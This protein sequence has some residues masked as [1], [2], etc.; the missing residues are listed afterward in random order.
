MVTSFKLKVVKDLL[1]YYHVLM[2]LK[3]LSIFFLIEINKKN[4][5]ILDSRKKTILKNN[6]SIKNLTQIL[7]KFSGRYLKESI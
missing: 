5:R 3:F 2:L 4:D 6:F 7:L 1:K